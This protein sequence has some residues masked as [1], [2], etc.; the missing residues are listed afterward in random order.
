MNHNRLPDPRVIF[1]LALFFSTYG[2]I[3]RDVIYMA[4]LLFLAIICGVALGVDFR[5]LFKQ[6]K[7]L[8]QVVLMV[9][10][11]QSL[12]A[13]SGTVIFELRDIPLLTIGGIMKGLTVLFRLVLFITSASMVALYPPR[14]LIQGMVQ[15]KL[16]YEIAYMVSIGVRFV[17]KMGEELKD[18]LTALQL[19]GIVIEELKLK[20]RLR[21]YSYLLLPVVAAS[22]QSAKE[23][24][25]SMEMRAFRAMRE[26]TSYYTLSFKRRDIVMLCVILFLT[27]LIGTAMIFLAPVTI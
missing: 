8:L 27:I 4:A 21:L 10:L 20:K 22:L 1:A 6:V 15:I 14:A 17:P 13:P 11:L 25:M 12:F 2:I 9:A 3:I 7:R 23:L 26:R 24:A 19:R 16:P 18:S 5:R